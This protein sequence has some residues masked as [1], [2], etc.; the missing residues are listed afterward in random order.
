VWIF[1]PGEPE[2]TVIFDPDAGQDPTKY[3][4]T[5]NKEIWIMTFT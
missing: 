5:L 3:S 2:K 4:S 1:D